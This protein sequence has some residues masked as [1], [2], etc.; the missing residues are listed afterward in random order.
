MIDEIRAF[1]IGDREESFEALKEFQ[2][3]WTEIGYVPVKE[4]DRLQAE[5]RETIDAH[6]SVLKG[7][8]RERK[9]ERFREK[10]GTM[11]DNRS[12]RSERE[13]LYNKVKQLEADIQLLENNIGFFAKSK[14]AEAMIRDVNAKIDKAKEEKAVLVE[15]IDLIDKQASE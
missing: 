13:R 12:V 2:R 8:V 7:T 5:Y 15:K 6:F 3:R 14:N 1:E 11:K 9:V 10:L 4:K